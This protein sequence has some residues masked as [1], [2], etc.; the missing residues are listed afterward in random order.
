MWNQ[1]YQ[2]VKLPVGSSAERPQAMLR[3]QHL[4][5]AERRFREIAEAYE[6]LLP[7]HV[8][9]FRPLF[10]VARARTFYGDSVL[11]HRGC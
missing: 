2:L 5:E 7:G 3:T 10:D 1:V 9:F 11:S 8:F 4:Q 6:A